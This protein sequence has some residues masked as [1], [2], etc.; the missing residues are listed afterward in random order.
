MRHFYLSPVK[1]LFNLLALLLVVISA[2]FSFAN[3]N[4]KG[5]GS[6]A[7]PPATNG[8]NQNISV[9]ENFTKQFNSTTHES[10]DELFHH[11]V[12]IQ[13]QLNQ[14]I[15]DKSDIAYR[16]GAYQEQMM[17]F[18]TKIFRGG[19]TW[20]LEYAESEH[21]ISG[22]D[23]IKKNLKA[24]PL[25]RKG[26]DLLKAFVLSYK[27]DEHL[28]ENQIDL[29]NA[30]KS[31][32]ATP[33]KF[34][35]YD[36]KTAKIEGEPNFKYESFDFDPNNT[37]LPENFEELRA[38]ERIDKFPKLMQDNLKGSKEQ[39]ERVHALLKENFINPDKK[40]NITLIGTSGNGKTQFAKAMAIALFGDKNAMKKLTFTGKIG[41]LS[42][43]FR[44][45][46]GY[47][48]SN[49]PTDFENWFVDRIESDKGGIIVLDE[50]L[51]FHGLS[52]EQIAHKVQTINELYDLLDERVV[53]IA[54]KTYDMSKFHVVITGNALQEAFASL[55][56]NPDADKE[57]EKILKRLTKKDIIN[58][59]NEVGIDAPK[60]ARFGEIFVNGPLPNSQVKE[61]SQ[62][63]LM[64]SIK[65]IDADV[66]IKIDQAIL[67]GVVSKLSTVELG[68]REVNIGLSKLVISSVNG[69]LFDIAEAKSI[70]AKL[71]DGVIR[72]YVDGE[73]VVL[74]SVV[75][76]DD[77][78]LEERKWISKKD[79]KNP[80]SVRTPQFDDLDINKPKN[81]ED[82]ELFITSVHEV[83]G[84]WMVNT[85]LTGKN[86]SQ[87]IS[88]V[89]SDGALGYVMPKE[90]DEIKASILTRI[91]KR[92]MM[93]EAGHRAPIL[94]GFVATGGGNH[95]HKK[96]DIPRDD[97]NKIE[98]NIDAIMA[99]HL[100]KEY[101]NVS[102][103]ETV[104]TFKIVLRNLMKESTD[105]VIEY[106][107]SIEFAD[108]LLDM[109]MTDRFLVEEVIDA[110][111]EKQLKTV[112]QDSDEL[113]FKSINDGV[114]KLLKSY[115]G[116]PSKEV[117]VKI[118]MI[119]NIIETSFMEV[120]AIRKF[121][122]ASDEFLKVLESIK[123]EGIIT[124]DKAAKQHKG[125]CLALL[126][127][128]GQYLKKK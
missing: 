16:S 56:D 110:Y 122:G 99:N 102:E 76:N 34:L 65:G 106:G 51:S 28:L 45:S 84:H 23:A 33:F 120:K 10:I 119:K 32:P 4:G 125:G 94:E 53:K 25:D 63:M 78:G 13:N 114:K 89:P 61:V 7:L 29:I 11:F 12:V 90:N 109:A 83:K 54:N 35:D 24:L 37:E 3:Q 81:V 18:F 59:F 66:K 77:S 26:I 9:I 6:G 98:S 108:G 2:D 27:G 57:I 50:L 62:L 69:I 44:S 71:E 103:K 43:Y 22:V 64:E 93:L 58:Y 14:I 46:T 36:Y 49:E 87:T 107:N 60:L 116:Q 96:G 72:W 30:L 17:S 92:N 21:F 5:P 115:E 113:F 8:T 111:T 85:L 39:I 95:M 75:V 31:K 52:K 124:L 104:D 19:P 73:E 97:L 68:M 47:V 70:E 112:T 55:Q 100:F 91:L 86:E 38:K 20:D 126:S 123:E 82:L 40:I 48:G 1:K 79:A 41:E 121:E 67:D 118:S 128:F 80:E 15:P 127:K 88:T 42:D 74:D 117:L 101:T 105:Y